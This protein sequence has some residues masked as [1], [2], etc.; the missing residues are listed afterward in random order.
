MLSTENNTIL[1]SNGHSIAMISTEEILLYNGQNVA[2]LST[3][4]TG[5]S[6]GQSAPLTVKNLLKIWK[7][8]EKITKKRENIGKKRKIRKVLSLC[9]SCQI[10]LA[11][12]LTEDNN[13]HSNAMLS[14]EHNTIWLSNEMTL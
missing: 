2:M 11:T 9:P 3:E 13:E 14:T 8:W 4:D 10:G 1:I 5:G 7:K 12:L 6:K